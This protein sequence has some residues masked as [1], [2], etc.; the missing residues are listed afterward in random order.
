MNGANTFRILTNELQNFAT[1]TTPNGWFTT[2]FTTGTI[3]CPQATCT[4]V[5][6]DDDR[7]LSSDDRA[8]TS[9]TGTYSDLTAYQYLK[10]LYAD[11]KRALT[12]QND[13]DAIS[14]VQAKAGTNYGK[15][16]NIASQVAD[17][18]QSEANA[19]TSLDAQAAQIY[20]AIDVLNADVENGT[21]TVDAQILQRNT[22][23]DQLTQVHTGIDN[24]K[25]QSIN[26]KSS[27][28]VGLLSQLASVA[29]Q[30]D[31]DAADKQLL[32]LYL[33]TAFV[34]IP[35][36]SSQKISLFTLAQLCEHTYGSAILQARAWYLAE[37]GD[38]I[39]GSCDDQIGER[40]T[41]LQ[42]YKYHMANTVAISPNPAY[43]N[44]TIALS[45]SPTTDC[46]VQIMNPLGQV[47]K[48]LQM[49]VGNE[50]LEVQNLQLPA[51]VYKLIVYEQDVPSAQA[52]LNISE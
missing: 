43:Q 22:L 17:L 42:P 49:Q 25:Q 28:K 50:R 16:T 4:L 6:T 1:V 52:T 45:W 21:S 51:G 5:S 13:G 24:A 29:P 3:G 26:A 34:Q 37:T 32:E 48:N 40:S 27:A 39:E 2:Q 12:L 9:G 46:T 47:V 19:L 15:L 10:H 35:L 11:A 38:M 44:F 23:D 30:A 20:A 41:G 14:F 7:V 31:Y 33:H 36:T 8:K 18:E